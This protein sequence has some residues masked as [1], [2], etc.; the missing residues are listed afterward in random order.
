MGCLTHPCEIREGVSMSK[1]FIYTNGQDLLDIC[2]LLKYR[3]AWPARN[4][5]SRQ[6]QKTFWNK[7][8]CM[9]RK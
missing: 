5:C 4:S 8:Y 6:M 3:R 7:R 9:S 1:K 2:Y